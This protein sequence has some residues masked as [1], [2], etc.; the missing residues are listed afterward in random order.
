MD[1]AGLPAP[2]TAADYGHTERVLNMLAQ[3]CRILNNRIDKYQRARVIS[4][5]SGQSDY[6]CGARRMAR[7]E[8]E[9][10][11]ILEGI[12]DHLQRRS[13]LSA[14]GKVPRSLGGRGLWSGGTAGVS[15]D[16]TEEASVRDEGSRRGYSGRC[17]QRR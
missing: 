6:A 1:L 10:R 8:E 7:I 12:I 17:V 15:C 3:I 2:A 4:E 5:A 11:R 14:S 9:E 13:P 16:D